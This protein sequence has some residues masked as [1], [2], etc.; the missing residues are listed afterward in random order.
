MVCSIIL[1]LSTIKTQSF[2][3]SPDYAK[4]LICIQYGCGLKPIYRI[5]SFLSAVGINPNIILSSLA[6]L[7]ASISFYSINI[8][9][10]DALKSVFKSNISL[11]IT[12]FI[13]SFGMLVFNFYGLS[14]FISR[15]NH[16]ASPVGH[17]TMQY[18]AISLVLFLLTFKNI[19]NTKLILFLTLIGIIVH[20]SVLLYAVIIGIS[21]TLNIK[22]KK[23]EG[24][25]N[26]KLYT[27]PSLK[28]RK[29]IYQKVVHSLFMFCILVL[30]SIL[31]VYILD[32][33]YI[34]IKLGTRSIE[35]FGSGATSIKNYIINLSIILYTLYLSIVNSNRLSTYTHKSSLIYKDKLLVTPLSI[36]ILFTAV[37]S[38]SIEI[39]G[40]SQ[41]AY[42]VGL[43][44]LILSVPM[45]IIIFFY[46]ISDI[47]MSNK[48]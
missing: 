4:S 23:D 42:R 5:L 11:Y 8:L 20:P 16:S 1:V 10:A 9:V 15:E 36:V 25:I 29:K 45:L 2:S 21:L 41:L 38:I 19:S 14:V 24:K 43:M 31:F 30:T 13:A 28:P 40:Q 22:N 34:I 48:Y 17:L 39:S 12:S 46:S 18:F 47:K 32:S 33:L 35:N 7:A 6:I 37:F 26:S 27:I 3:L 44:N